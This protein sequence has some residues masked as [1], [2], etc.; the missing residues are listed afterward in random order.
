MNLLDQGKL[1]HLLE[2]RYFDGVIHFAVK[3]LLGESVKNPDLYYRNNVV[4]TLN[5]VSEMLN[6]EVDNLVF[7]STAAILGNPVTDIEDPTNF[8]LMGVCDHFYEN[9]VMDEKV[10]TH[11]DNLPHHC[12][13]M[14]KPKLTMDHQHND[15]PWFGLEKIAVNNSFHKY[16]RNYASRLI[17]VGI[18]ND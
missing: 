7:S 5:L 6:N 13:L 3:S 10:S 14:E 8:K 18:D 1:S 17:N 12:R 9:S 11:Y 16:I 15:L 4:G 2:G